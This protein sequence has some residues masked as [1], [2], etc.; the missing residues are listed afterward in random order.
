MI[1]ILARKISA[2]ECLTPYQLLLREDSKGQIII[3]LF[4]LNKRYLS[5]DR[6]LKLGLSYSEISIEPLKLR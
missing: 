4:L 1:A 6:H 2:E 5:E 3:V